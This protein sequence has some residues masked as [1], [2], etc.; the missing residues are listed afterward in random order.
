MTAEY[1]CTHCSRFV[2]EDEVDRTRNGCIGPRADGRIV[3]EITCQRCVA[4][5]VTLACFP[6]KH[7]PAN[8]F[9]VWSSMNEVMCDF[10]SRFD[11]LRERL[12]MCTS[13]SQ[14]RAL[15]AQEQ[16][17]RRYPLLP[18]SLPIEGWVRCD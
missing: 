6:Q 3:Y 15:L 8:L 16:F 14:A 9:D 18:E 2:G 1:R 11:V 5:W 7:R 4:D 10:R 17:D 13:L 12:P